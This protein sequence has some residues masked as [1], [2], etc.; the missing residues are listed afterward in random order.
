MS[1]PSSIDPVNQPRARA[2]GWRRRALMS[3]DRNLLF[4]ILA[5][6][7]DFISREQ[8]VEAMNAWVQNSERPLGELLVEGGALAA[9]DRDLL[10]PMVERHLAMHGGDPAKSL[11]ALNPAAGA[12]PREVTV[13]EVPNLLAQLTVPWQGVIQV[14]LPGKDR[15]ASSPQE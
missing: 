8:L 13:A 14:R 11:A 2:G 12:A 1:S 4:G 15:P 7:M 3:A 10:A 5:L 6:R 9:A